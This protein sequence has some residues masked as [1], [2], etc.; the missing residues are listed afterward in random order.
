MHAD[1]SDLLV[2]VVSV[3]LEFVLAS[4]R[5][6]QT[7]VVALT[8]Y[9]GLKTQINQS[10]HLVQTSSATAKARENAPFVCVYLWLT[11]CQVT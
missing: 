4:F 2:S 5:I 7:K 3:C 6:L 9:D 1:N 10:T 11:L 8:K